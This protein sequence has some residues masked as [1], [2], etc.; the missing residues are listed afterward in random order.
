[1]PGDARDEEVAFDQLHRFVAQVTPKILVRLVP[2]L[3]NDLR[4][5]VHKGDDVF[6]VM[7]DDEIAVTADVERFK[8]G[9]EK[10]VT[11]ADVAHETGQ[12]GLLVDD[13]TF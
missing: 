6:H 3:V 12:D 5:T 11:L 13:L 8:L 4:P 7:T 10:K 9:S 2:C 1:M